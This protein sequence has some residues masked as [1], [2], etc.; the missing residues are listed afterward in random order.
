MKTTTFL[1][2]VSIS[3]A[4]FISSSSFSQTE[5]TDSVSLGGSIG[6]RGMWQ[7][8]NLNQVSL[9]PTGNLNLTAKNH[10]VQVSGNYQF[11]IVEGFQVKNDLWS[12]GLYQYKPYNLF[13]PSASAVSGFAA[14]YAIDHSF[15]AGLGV[16]LNVIKNQGERYFQLHLHAGYLDFKFEDQIA[17]QS[18]A[19]SSLLRAKFPL[20]KGFVIGWELGSYHAMKE[21]DFWGGDNLLQVMVRLNNNLSASVSHQTFYNHK[22]APNIQNTNTQLLFGLHY[23]PRKIIHKSI[24]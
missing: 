10:F 13:F 16:G 12:Y 15:V 8:G 23:S 22:A 1:T 24:K 19:F 20:K 11:L 2:L 5:P 21:T 4:I 17:L 3:I 7:T 18:F 9:M 14:S 6:I